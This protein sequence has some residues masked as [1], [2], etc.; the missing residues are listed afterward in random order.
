[1]F[2]PER[3]HLVLLAH[4]DDEA[5][6]GG[7]LQ[8]LAPRRVVWLTNGDGLAPAEGADPLEYARVRRAE[9]VKALAEVGVGEDRLGFLDFSEIDIYARLAG[10]VQGTGKAAGLALARECFQAVLA[11]VREVQPEVVWTLAYQGGHPEHDLVHLCAFHAARVAGRERGRPI[12]VYELPEYEFLFLV[13][14]RF[15]PWRR[16]PCHEIRLT[17]DEVARKAALA[18]SYPSQQAIVGAF[19]KLIGV[20]GALSA[21]RGRPF[22][23]QQFGAREQFAPVPPDRDH[24]RSTHLSPRL[25][26][27]RDDFQGTPIRFERTLSLIAADL[28]RA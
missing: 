24:T 16:L 10:M 1:V 2:A 14:L 17:P 27:I 9:S 7:L 21:L 11:Q 3:R 15:K 13:P 5:G 8:R 19:R 28:A 4:Q 22:S 18:A 20:Y 12:P 25:D 6:Y 23:F 26:Y